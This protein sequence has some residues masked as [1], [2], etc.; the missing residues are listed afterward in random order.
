MSIIIDEL[1]YIF[2]KEQLIKYGKLNP[3]YVFKIQ[4]YAGFYVPMYGRLAIIVE[5][6]ILTIDKK[7]TQWW[8]FAL[9]NESE[10]DYMQDLKRRAHELVS[11]DDLIY[12]FASRAHER[13]T[14]QV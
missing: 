8:N 9:F 13:L 5:D 14:C 3:H 7:E 6:K 12:N 11:I 1:Q 4:N 10:Q 2:R